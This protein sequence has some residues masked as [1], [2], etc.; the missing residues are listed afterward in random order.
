MKW[1]GEVQFI[2][3]E[4]PNILDQHVSN[5]IVEELLLDDVNGDEY[6]DEYGK[7]FVEVAGK[8]SAEL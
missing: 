7:L 6:E 2:L 3:Y 4:G 8:V 1:K 5:F